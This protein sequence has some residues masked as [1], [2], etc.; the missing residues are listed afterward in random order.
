MADTMT[1]VTIAAGVSTAA[2]LAANIIARVF[3]SGQQNGSVKQRLTSIET[4]ILGMQVDFKK[5]TDVLI[6]QADMQAR[7][8]R[9]EADIRDLRHGR[10]FVTPRSEDGIN[11]EWP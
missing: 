5:L 11:G 2:T 6:N 10:G 8:T 1:T 9:A 3:S 7:V 4:A